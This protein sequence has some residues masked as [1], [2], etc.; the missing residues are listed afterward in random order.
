MKPYGLALP[1]AA[2]EC[3]GTAI[4]LRPNNVYGQTRNASRFDLIGDTPEL[5]QAPTASLEPKNVE[6]VLGD[7]FFASGQDEDGDEVVSLTAS[8]D[9]LWQGDHVLQNVI[10]SMVNMCLY[11]EFHRAITEGDIGCA[12]EIIKVH[13]EPCFASV[14]STDLSLNH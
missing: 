7:D 13:T 6:D 1:A 2:D 11:L 5:D 10:Q 8:P 4:C 9:L 14:G 12:F 3:C